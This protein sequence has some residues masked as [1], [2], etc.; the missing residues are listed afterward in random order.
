MVLGVLHALEGVVEMK[1]GEVLLTFQANEKEA[2]EEDEPELFEFAEK[3]DQQTR[4]QESERIEALVGAMAWIRQTGG[5]TMESMVNA[6][7][8]GTAD[9]G[10]RDVRAP[11]TSSMLFAVA[12]IIEILLAK[13][14]VG[15]VSRLAV[16]GSVVARELNR[17]NE[18]TRVFNEAVDEFRD[19]GNGY[20]S[21][22]WYQDEEQAEKHQK[23]VGV[24]PRWAGRELEAGL[25]RDLEKCKKAENESETKSEKRRD[26]YLDARQ[27][28]RDAD[29]EWRHNKALRVWTSNE[30]ELVRR[31]RR[32]TTAR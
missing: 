16:L 6:F 13:A 19:G 15:D 24:V 27:A 1:G 21:A 22:P 31:K 18:C 5:S 11:E 12:T 7:R 30:L 28:W 20:G 3:F 8:Q 26:E 4:G 17:Q 14:N 23:S 25:V 32:R 9:V 29:E 10:G 2:N